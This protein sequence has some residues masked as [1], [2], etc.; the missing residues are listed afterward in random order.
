MKGLTPNN[1]DSV[2]AGSEPIDNN[3][4]FNFEDEDLDEIFPA[5][6]DEKSGD[7][8]SK[9]SD[10]DEKKEDKSAPANDKDTGSNSDKDKVPATED[11]PAKYQGKSAK[12]LL[13]I[14]VENENFN[15][16]QTKDVG[17]LRSKVEELTSEN[18]R[19]AA[20]ASKAKP[21]A[22]GSSPEADPYQA[23][24]SQ[25]EG[26]L[27]DGKITPSEYA[28]SLAVMNEARTSQIV[29]S[30]LARSQEQSALQAAENQYLEMNPD[31][32]DLQASGALDKIKA[33]FPV[34]DNVSAFEFVKRL[35]V[36]SENEELKGQ[37][38]TLK[39]EQADAIAAGKDATKKVLQQPGVGVKAEAKPRNR[40]SFSENEA[41]DSMLGA[42]QRTRES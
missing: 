36:Q 5:L 37:L 6:G 25:L 1:E 9:A 34:H 20:E 3:G 42:M 30:E 19:L 13:S 18:K 2:P 32:K 4:V 35:Q 15:G 28:K 17:D 23:K 22:D 29:Q 40:R 38:L 8:K 7:D 41:V 10:K 24:L 11:V 26:D 12:E 21:A 27:E 31:F 39:K 14:L 33:Q 16:K